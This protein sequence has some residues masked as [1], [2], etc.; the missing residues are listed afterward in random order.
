MFTPADKGRP[1]SV[2]YFGNLDVL[3]FLLSLFVLVYHL[4]VISN[5]L[6]LPS[7]SKLPLLNKGFLAVNWFFVLSGFLLSHLAKKEVQA[8]RFSIRKFI[9]RRILRIWPVYFI[10]TFIGIALYYFILP[11]LHIPFENRASLATAVLLSV[12]FLSNILHALYD[13]GGILTITWSVSIEEQFYLFFPLA[14]V[15]FFR[16]LRTRVSAV[17]AA[18]VLL[19]VIHTIWP[20]PAKGLE[21]FGA[22]FEL[23][24]IGILASELLPYFKGAKA[25]TKKALLVLAVA[26][27]AVSFFTPVFD[28]ND[29]VITRVLNGS[30]AALV[31]LILST[32][33]W[34]IKFRILTTGGKISYGIYMYH[35][36]VITGVVFITKTF[37]FDAAWHSPCT[38]ILVLNIVSILITYC[39]ALLSYNTIERYFLSKK[40]Y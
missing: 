21:Y 19:F 16:N 31:I 20:T 26:I 9:I 38:A 4:P 22:Y 30:M 33:D 34:N 32:S 35:M 15:A 24:F 3:R 8:G 36:I 13:P 27:F 1:G 5:S 25:R 7:F 11:F 6:G 17:S 2:L 37:F 18:F 40:P 39:S 12:F 23:F 10:V 14:V 29:H 28:I